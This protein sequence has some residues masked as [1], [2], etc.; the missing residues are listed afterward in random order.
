MTGAGV[1]GACWDEGGG[2]SCFCTDCSGA[3]DA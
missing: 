2:A 1:G 3:A